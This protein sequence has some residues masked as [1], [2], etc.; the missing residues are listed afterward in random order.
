MELPSLSFSGLQDLLKTAAPYAVGAAA[1][2]G[3]PPLLSAGSKGPEIGD[4]KRDTGLGMDTYYAGRNYGQQSPGSFLQI[5]PTRATSD[6]GEQ[7]RIRAIQQRLRA[8]AARDKGSTQ[9]PSTDKGSSM[10][11]GGKVV[12][13][14]DEPGQTKTDGTLPGPTTRSPKQEDE[15]AFR[16]IWAEIVRQLDPEVARKRAEIDTENFIRRELITNALSMRQS[17]ETT[18]R[19]VELKNI[20]AWKALE[21]ARIQANTQQTIATAQ[22]IALA[23]TPNQGLS[24][25]LSSAYGNALK[26]FETFNLK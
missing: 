4:V 20:E 13:P 21:Q 7:A 10:P 14:A 2:V 18:A 1:G 11:G 15:K 25:A 8:D 22:T 9:M 26:P 19:Q 12:P 3:I 24:S 16:D 17:R 6:S 23:L 5:D